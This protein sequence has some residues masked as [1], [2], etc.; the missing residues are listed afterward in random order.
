M[1][2]HTIHNLT[3]SRFNFMVNPNLDSLANRMVWIRKWRHKTRILY[4]SIKIIADAICYCQ[5]LLDLLVNPHLNWI[6][7][8]NPFLLINVKWCKMV[9][10]SQTKPTDLD[11]RSAYRLLSSTPTTA[12]HY[13]WARYR[14]G[15]WYPILSATAV[16]IPILSCTNFCCTE[17]AILCRG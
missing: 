11:R 1:R 16:P 9:A 14:A 17:N 13:Y 5:A 6:K 10:D 2:V 8:A 4:S 15:A 7:R 12:I 3:E